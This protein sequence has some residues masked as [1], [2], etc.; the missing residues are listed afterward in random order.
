MKKSGKQTNP[1]K[2]TKRFAGKSKLRAT[3]IDPRRKRTVT[4]GMSAEMSSLE[5]NAGKFARY[6]GQWLLLAEGKLLA[7]SGDYLVIAHEIARKGLKDGLVYYVPKP[8]ESEFIL[9]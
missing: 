5:E 6:A 2:V 9:V 7:H 3:A 4:S 1:R 8:E